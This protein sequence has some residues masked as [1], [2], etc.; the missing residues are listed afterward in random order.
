MFMW[1]QNQ[2]GN[3]GERA[4]KQNDVDLGHGALAPDPNP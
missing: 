4:G 1:V 3:Y 2:G